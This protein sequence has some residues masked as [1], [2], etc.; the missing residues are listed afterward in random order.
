M[1]HADDSSVTNCT[2][3]GYA[4]EGDLQNLVHAIPALKSTIKNAARVVDVHKIKMQVTV[5]LLTPL[6]S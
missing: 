4:L 2:F 6:C 3:P 1:I 5:T